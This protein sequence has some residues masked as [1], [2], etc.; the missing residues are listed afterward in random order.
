MLML[1]FAR[2]YLINNESL[3]CRLYQ[4]TSNR[5][6]VGRADLIKKSGRVPNNNDFLSE[7][8]RSE[9]ILWI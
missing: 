5:R 2:V 8:L 4:P 3:I 6:L 7:R 1:V 9:F